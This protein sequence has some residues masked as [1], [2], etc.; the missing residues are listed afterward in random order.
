MPRRRP[1][2]VR[3][4]GPFRYAWDRPVPV[5]P[6]LSARGQALVARHERSHYFPGAAAHAWR[7]WSAILRTEA[8]HW[9]LDY[10]SCYACDSLG[11]N[12]AAE[13]RRMLDEFLAVMPRDD[14]RA[15]RRRIAELDLP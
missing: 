1:A 13:L 8:P 9:C 6:H 7:R 11:A 10:D 2:D 4:D 5:L 14:A 15:W 12:D 3:D